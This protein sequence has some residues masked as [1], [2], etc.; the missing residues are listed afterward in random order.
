MATLDDLRCEYGSMGVGPVLYELLGNIVWATVRMYPAREYSPYGSWDDAACEDVLNDWIVD[1]LWGRADLQAMLLAASSVKQLRA[2]LT[3]SLRQHLTNRRRRSIAGNLYR[4]VKS[5]LNHDSAFRPVG[6][7]FG[8]AQRWTLDEQPTSDPSHLSSRELFA[9]AS[10]LSD[11]D[12]EVVRYGPYSQKLSPILREPK[13]RQFTLHL[14]RRSRG[15]LALSEIVDVMRLRFSLLQEEDSELGEDVPSVAREPSL[16][17]A[18]KEAAR[19]VVSRLEG[20]EVQLLVAF[21][22]AGGNEDLAARASHSEIGE[23]RRAVRH[24]YQM[25]VDSSDS[26]E[27]AQTIEQLVESLFL[28]GGDL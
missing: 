7:P 22:R 5:L 1:R 8:A 9:I 25:I 13:L 21:F 6:S 20:D 11:D 23:V 17:V 24:A 3:T 16:E 28:N 19:S 14:L 26:M 18:L 4:R 27:E 2:A 15:S 12:L 10:E